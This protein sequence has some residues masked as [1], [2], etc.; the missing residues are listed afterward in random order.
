MPL[1]SSSSSEGVLV[2]VVEV[3]AA[4]AA[5][6]MLV[7]PLD[8]S[9]RGS[10]AVDTEDVSTVRPR[11]VETALTNAELVRVVKIDADQSSA[12]AAP[13]SAKLLTAS[14][15]TVQVTDVRRRRTRDDDDATAKFFMSASAMPVLLEILVLSLDLSALVAGAKAVK[16]RLTSTVAVS[17]LVGTSVGELVGEGTGT[18]VGFRTGTEVGAG[19]GSGV[20]SGVGEGTGTEV[21]L[22]TGTMVG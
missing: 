15:D 16:L 13:S 9:M 4:V 3:E 18:N 8:G 19:K 11:S 20:G 1:S 14:K 10:T 22:G 7:G 2:A 12:L 21:G 17:N 6:G 5:T